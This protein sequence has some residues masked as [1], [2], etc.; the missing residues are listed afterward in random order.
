MKRVP[1]KTATQSPLDVV[2]VTFNSAAAIDGLLDSL[3]AA[4]GDVAFRTVVVD[5]TST[6]ETVDI[7]R[8]R[9]DAVLVQATNLG[10]GTGINTGVAVLA[11]TGPILALNPDV[12]LDP[13]S[14][15]TMV[16]ELNSRRAGVVVPRLRGEDEC[17]SRSLRREPTVWRSLGLGNSNLPRFSE[18]VNEPEAY[19]CVH[20]ADWATGAVLLIDRACY[21]ALD[22]FDEHFFMYS[23]ETDFCLRA[24]DVG[25]PTF[26]VPHAGA[27]HV[28]GGSGR[29]PE[30]YAM[31]VLNRIRL[32]R[33]R[34]SLAASVLLWTLAFGRELAH[35][36][37]GNPESRRAL[38]ALCSRGRKPTLLPW[39]GGPLR[40]SEPCRAQEGARS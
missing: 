10:F 12:R 6:D 36:L 16:N 30:L 28:G 32:Y 35:A 13:D 19:E 7:V 34:H 11:D 21:E 37:S 15:A 26:F 1:S 39:P 22:G 40:R 29:S 27:V 4:C 5:N 8:N 25:M 24:R 31:Q 17:L 23:E 9:N 3:P 33:R 14:V 2:I 18:I 38:A 20:P